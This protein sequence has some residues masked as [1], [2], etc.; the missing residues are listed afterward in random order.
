MPKTPATFDARPSGR[1]DAPPAYEVRGKRIHFMGVAG[2]GMSAIARMAQDQGAIVSG[3]DL[4]ANSET[5]RL[6]AQGVAVSLGHHGDHIVPDLDLVV[7]T[8]AIPAENGEL[9]CAR[10]KGVEVISRLRMLSRLMAGRESIAVAGAHGKTTTTWLAGNLLIHAGLDPTLMVGGVVPPLKGNFRRGAGRHFVIEV[11]ESDG[12]FTEI[13]PTWSILT[14][15]DREHLDHYSGLEEICETFAI[16][17]ANTRPDGCV[18]ACADDARVMDIVSASGRRTVTYALHAPGDIRAADVRLAEAACRF[19][20]RG[21]DFEYRDLCIEMPGEHNIQNALAVVALSRLLGIGE[22]ILRESLARCPRVRRRFE[23]KWEC[24]QVR[25][26]DDY[27]HHPT[28]II[29][30]LKA[31]R[32]WARGRLIVVFQ[33]HRYSRT[34]LLLEEFARAFNLA[35]HLVVT[36]IYSANEPPLAGITGGTLASAAQRAG[37]RSVQFIP[38]RGRILE[39]LASFA[40]PGDT[41]ITMGAGDIGSLGDALQERLETLSESGLREAG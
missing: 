7:R 5:R 28:E 29:A 36:S 30:T 13:R 25:L 23:I 39:H 2:I 15:I 33:P 10:E 19:T 31:A 24:A 6:E 11:D 37:V 18:I 12:L 26:I 14:N 16:Y 38:K 4:R 32:R 35:D 21:P 41:I 20:A 22:P 1:T 40:K 8:S 9:M 34:L 27:A 3:C 17:V